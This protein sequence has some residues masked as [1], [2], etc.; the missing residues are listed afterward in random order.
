MP[1]AIKLD[2]KSS[3]LIL[4]D[5]INAVAKGNGPPYN[6][7]PNRQ[8]VIDN[9][10]RLVAHCREVGTPIIYITTYRR[11]DNS[12][13]PKTVADVGGG[14]GAAMLEGTPAVELSMSWP[15]NQGTTSS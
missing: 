11:A 13:A 2:P 15:R 9:F 8:G 6:V 3:A 14:G 7:P 1:E 4:I 5:M 10:V 12:D